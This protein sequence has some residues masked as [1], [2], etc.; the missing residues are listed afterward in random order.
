[1]G[2]YKAR[3]LFTW[4]AIAQQLVAL[5]EHHTHEGVDMADTEWDEP[6][7]DTD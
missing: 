4:A 7:T 1:M 2:A 5:A 6:W 3:S